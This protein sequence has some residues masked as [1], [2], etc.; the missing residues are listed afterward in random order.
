MYMNRRKFGRPVP[1]TPL[2]VY[3][4]P[5]CLDLAFESL[6]AGSCAIMEDPFVCYND[7]AEIPSEDEATEACMP[8]V[9]LLPL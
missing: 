1:P 8:A 6:P 3:Y 4:W 7:G 2:Q 5:I 9:R